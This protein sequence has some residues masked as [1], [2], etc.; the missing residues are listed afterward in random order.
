MC[1]ILKLEKNKKYNNIRYILRKPDVSR[2][3]K[4][5]RKNSK[6]QECDEIDRTRSKN[7]TRNYKSIDFMYK[8]IKKKQTHA[9]FWYYYC[10]VH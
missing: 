4:N 5:E 1:K 8:S 9:C 2:L 3:D 7:F 6:F 10:C